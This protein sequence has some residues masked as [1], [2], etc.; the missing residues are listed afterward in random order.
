MQLNGGVLLCPDCGGLRESY[1]KQHRR[2]LGF[3]GVQRRCCCCPP[4]LFVLVTLVDEEDEC[5]CWND[6]TPGVD[7]TLSR[8]MVMNGAYVIPKTS[9]TSSYC[10]YELLQ[11]DLETVGVKDIF[12]THNG[13]C[14]G[15][16]VSSR[17][18]TGRR[19]TIV[20]EI[21]SVANPHLTGYVISA[22]V[23]IIYTVSGSDTIEQWY[24]GLDFPLAANALNEERCL[25][26][27]DWTDAGTLKV[28]TKWT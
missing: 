26:Y 7:D 8:D 12:T 24:L 19:F 16:A 3:M 21:D 23:D 27:G 11:E 9:E 18:F 28:T 25:G 17:S 5:G 2:R 1:L 13:T 10:R 22:K 15:T 20:L 4:N 14:A 6:P